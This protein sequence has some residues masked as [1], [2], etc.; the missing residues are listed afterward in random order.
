MIAQ[1]VKCGVCRQ[2]QTASVFLNSKGFSNVRPLWSIFDV[3]VLKIFTTIYRTVQ[4]KRTDKT[5]LQTQLKTAA[6]NHKPQDDIMT[7]RV[8]LAGDSYTDLQ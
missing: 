8:D 4:D 6:V 5:Q 3:F 1:S 7:F 2:F